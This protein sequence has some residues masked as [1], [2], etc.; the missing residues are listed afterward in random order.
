M[1]NHIVSS[2][3]LYKKPEKDF[4][5][6]KECLICLETIDL[7]VAKIVKLPCGCSNS[8]Y[9]IVCIA[10]LLSSGKNKNFCPH[11]KSIYELTLQQVVQPSNLIAV[12]PNTEN[13]QT[14]TLSYIILVHI[15]SNSIMNIINIGLSHDYSKNDA[16][17]ISKI[18]QISYFCK[19]LVNVCIII[20]LKVNVKQINSHLSLSYIIQAVLF[21]LLICLLSMIET[22]F[23][24]IIMLLNNVFFVIT[25]LGFRI[26]IECKGMNRVNVIESV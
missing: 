13:E 8:V 5:K 9:H 14:R 11:C 10:Q 26:R 4:L 16:N 25:D 2:L 20:N 23:N 21:V 17:I 19:I 1:A 22:N 6:D 12:Q 15:F 7:E 24:S 3:Q 18:L